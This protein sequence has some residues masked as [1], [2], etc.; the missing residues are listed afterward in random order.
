MAGTNLD[1]TVLPS[2][3]KTAEYKMVG[4]LALIWETSNQIYLSIK[5]ECEI[6]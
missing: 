2:K 4:K 1:M 5:K 3:L 6:S